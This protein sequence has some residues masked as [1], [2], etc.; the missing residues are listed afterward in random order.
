MDWLKRE[1]A[2]ISDQQWTFLISMLTLVNMV[3]LGGLVWLLTI[4]STGQFPVVLAQ[5]PAT[6]LRCP[7]LP[8]PQA[9]ILPPP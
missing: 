9:L 1:M 6:A 2:A 5:A 7:P 3:I 4:Q 8:Q